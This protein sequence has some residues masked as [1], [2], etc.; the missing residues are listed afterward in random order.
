MIAN[1]MTWLQKPNNK[2]TVVIVALSL[3]W[4]ATI[5][6]AF[7]NDQ[8]AAAHVLKETGE[9]AW[10]L[11][12]FTI[13]IG[14]ASKIFVGNRFIMTLLP[15]RNIL[16]FLHFV[17]RYLILYFFLWVQNPFQ[18]DSLTSQEIIF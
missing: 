12:L 13:F 1:A 11:I 8:R 7:G 15:L 18:K 6:P 14:L 17:L 5:L 16:V 3:L 4:I 10:Q 2:S 9:L